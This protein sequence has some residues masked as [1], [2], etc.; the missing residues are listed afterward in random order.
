[1]FG[2]RKPDTP[3]STDNSSDASRTASRSSKPDASA[4]LE[5]QP[6]PPVRPA[7]Y[8]SGGAGSAAA[9]RKPASSQGGGDGEM[10]KLIVGRDIRLAGE[11]T[12]CD[13]LVV[14]GQ[15]EADLADAQVL[16]IA[17]SGLFKGRAEVD[18]AEV[19]G[20]F[21]GELTVRERLVLRSTGQVKGTLRYAE[22]EI[23]RGGRVNGSIEEIAQQQLGNGASKSKVAAVEGDKDTP[24]FGADKK[25]GKG[26]GESGSAAKA[27]G[28]AG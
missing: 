7:G 8:Q 27:G 6:Q 1:M 28:A 9:A 18:I 11:I 17:E 16:E 26:Q 19:S 15:V 3:Q 5:R 2:K 13:K 12:A 20:T 14:E 23:E 25:D 21:D 10:K 22:L 4:L 24:M